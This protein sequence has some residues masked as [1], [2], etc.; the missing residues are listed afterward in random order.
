MI[1]HINFSLVARIGTPFV[2]KSGI[3]N[4]INK[5]LA[6]AP[7]WENKFDVPELNKMYFFLDDD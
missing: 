5:E 2:Y 6:G 3:K 1:V 4:E 7:L